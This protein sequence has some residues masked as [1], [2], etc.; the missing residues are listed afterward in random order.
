M[1]IEEV[2]STFLLLVFA[3]LIWVGSATVVLC[4]FFSIFGFPYLHT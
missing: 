4:G 3:V 2:V 1:A